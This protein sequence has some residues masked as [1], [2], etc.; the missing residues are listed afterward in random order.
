MHVSGERNG[1]CYA[2]SE[3]A[4]SKGTTLS[5]ADRRARVVWI[6]IGLDLDGKRFP[7]AVEVRWSILNAKVLA[8]P[9]LIPVAYLSMTRNQLQLRVAGSVPNLRAVRVEQ[10]PF[11][12]GSCEFRD[13]HQGAAEVGPLALDV[14]QIERSASCCVEE[15]GDV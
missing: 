9:P 5:D 4:S 11:E 15:D 13:V 1:R 3:T 7:S 10:L 8:C 6:T 12:Y 2:L 14:N